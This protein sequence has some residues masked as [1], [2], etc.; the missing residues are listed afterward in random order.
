MLFLPVGMMKI[1]EGTNAENQLD[2]TKPN[3]T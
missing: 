1:T 3:K 2:F